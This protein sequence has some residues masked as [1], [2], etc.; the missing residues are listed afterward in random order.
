MALRSGSDGERIADSGGLDPDRGFRVRRG[1]GNAVYRRG[2]E[3]SGI[4]FQ[5]RFEQAEDRAVFRTVE[6]AGE[7]VPA[8][9]EPLH[10]GDAE[11]ARAQFDI[12]IGHPVDQAQIV[13]HDLAMI[14][15]IHDDALEE[16]LVGDKA[17]PVEPFEPVDAWVMADKSAEL[18]GHG[19]PLGANKGARI[20]KIA[21]PDARPENPAQC[22]DEIM[23]HAVHRI[24]ANILLIDRTD[25]LPAAVRAQEIADIALRFE[26]EILAAE[27]DEMGP[28]VVHLEQ[29]LHAPQFGIDEAVSAPLCLARFEYLGGFIRGEKLC[30]IGGKVSA[31]ILV[32]MDEILVARLVNGA[33]QALELL[34]VTMDKDKIGY[35]GNISGSRPYTPRM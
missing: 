31:G 19:F 9:R 6:F 3:A 29:S 11:I 5:M 4:R 34:R 22:L 25:K 7:Q 17:V 23:R 13:I 32:D 33:K 28:F 14:A 16:T 12:A 2:E 26:R 20:R 35:H 30:N 27:I 18:A 21:A 1:D 8:L 24:G 15:T 10:V